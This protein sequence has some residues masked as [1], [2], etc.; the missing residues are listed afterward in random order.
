MT[1]EREV[2]LV[3]QYRHGAR[4]T[5]TEIPGGSMVS[6]HESPLSAAQR[7][8]SEETG[9]ASDHW[10]ELAQLAAH[11]ASQDYPVYLYLALDAYLK[12][13]QKLDPTED[14]EVL[15]EPFDT[16]A[17]MI[18]RREVQS[19]GSAAGLLLARERLSTVTGS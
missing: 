13:E 8:L 9:Y 4:E 17:E 16:V 1:P 2:I 3:R 14:I 15:R 7:E 12:Y 5:L 10:F 6:E 19:L 11:P 18:Q